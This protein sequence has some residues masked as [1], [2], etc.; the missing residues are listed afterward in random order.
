[1][2]YMKLERVPSN[3]SRMNPSTKRDGFLNVPPIFHPDHFP[4]Q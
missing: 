3:I 1:M 2:E 4:I